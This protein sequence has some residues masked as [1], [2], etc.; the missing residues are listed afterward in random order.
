M[1]AGEPGGKPPEVFDD[2][3]RMRRLAREL[4]LWDVF[5]EVEMDV[6]QGFGPRSVPREQ[7]TVVFV[8]ATP[9]VSPTAIRSPT[10]TPVPPT[11]IPSPT[12]LKPTMAPRPP[13]NGRWHPGHRSTDDGA[14]AAARHDNGAGAQVDAQRDNGTGAQVDAQ[15][16]NGTGAQ[17]DAAAHPSGHGRTTGSRITRTKK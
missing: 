8:T 7:V 11:T 2:P 16:E 6:Q 9:F 4:G 1:G 5:H 17:A 14:Q 12:P 15:R 3:A 10:P 13:L